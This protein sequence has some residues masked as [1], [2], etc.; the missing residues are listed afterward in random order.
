MA[1]VRISCPNCGR[2][3][4]DTEQS[5]DAVLNCNGCKNRVRIRMTVTN[6]KD[7]IRTI[8]QE[9]KHDKSK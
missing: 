4:G 7:Y 8:K 1:G 5:I 3:L 6:F 9:Q 2:I